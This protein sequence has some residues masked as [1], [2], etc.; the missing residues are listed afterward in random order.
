MRIMDGNNVFNSDDNKNNKDDKNDKNND[1]NKYNKNNMNN[2]NNDKNDNNNNNENENEYQ[3]IKNI[4]VSWLTIN[5]EAAFS[6]RTN[7]FKVQHLS[8]IKFHG[9]IRISAHAQA[10]PILYRQPLK[11]LIIYGQNL[12]EQFLSLSLRSNDQQ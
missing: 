6:A 5:F 12:S 2:K 3:Q 10:C 4:S 9:S 8:Q 7:L 1:N 11:S